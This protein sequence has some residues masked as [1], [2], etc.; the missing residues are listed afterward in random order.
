MANHLDE[1]G[2]PKGSPSSAFTNKEMW[3]RVDAKLDTLVARQQHFDVEL[4]LLKERQAQSEAWREA[5]ETAER[6]K[7]D[8]AT[9]ERR[10]IAETV[11]E[12]EHD[13]AMRLET[14]RSNQEEISARQKATAYIV[15]AVV[16][17]ANILI[18]IIFHFTG[19]PA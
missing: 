4:A 13:L 3:V 6:E 17:I 5:H 8:A 12:T 7:R 2:L 15:G 11:S 19:G 10:R 16:I 14:L 18:P 1:D 9:A